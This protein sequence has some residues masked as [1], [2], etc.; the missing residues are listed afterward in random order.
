MLEQLLSAEKSLPS[1]LR[2]ADWQSLFINYEKLFVERLWIPWNEYGLNLHII[3]PC[4]EEE[5]FFHP[6]PWASAMKIVNGIYEMKIGYGSGLVEPVTA[7]TCWL[8][9]NSYYE[10]T[11]IDSW[12]S[13]RPLGKPVMSVMLTGKPWNRKMPKNDKVKLSCLL[14]DRKSA[15]LSMFK[16]IYY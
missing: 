5:S 2:N 10:M 6:H 4:D 16:E 11:N 14:D 8:N 3:H 13:V 7:I 12:H 9:P 1:L 15:I